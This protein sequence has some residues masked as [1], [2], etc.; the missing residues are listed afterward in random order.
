MTYKI[1]IADDEIEILE[2]LELCLEKEGFQVFKAE[3]GLKAW[4]IIEEEDINIA[5]IDIMMPVIDGFKLT[6]KIRESY[7]IPIIILSAKNQDNDKILG[8]GLGADDYVTK[9]FNPLEIVA[10]VQAQIRRF[11]NL[12]SSSKTIKKDI[13]IGEIELDTFNSTVKVKGNNKDLT[14]TEYKIL[15]LLMEGAGRIFTKKRYI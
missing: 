15:K 11:Y 1:L 6:K 5:I 13:K 9:P 3:D 12:N 2:I 14:A 8:L 4:K 10:R 7:N